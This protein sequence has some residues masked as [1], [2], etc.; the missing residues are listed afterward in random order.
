MSFNDDC[1]YCVK[2]E[3]LTDIMIEICKLEASTLYLFKEQTYKG[4]CVV[5]YNDHKSEIFELND[6]E[7]SLYMKDVARVAG[8][9]NKA[10]SPYKINYGAYADKMTHL[11]F[12]IVP[13]YEDGPSFGG[14]F[15]MSPQNKV[16]LKDDEYNQLINKIKEN[17]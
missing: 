15:E 5:A 8:A 6:D 10:F 12:H 3:R 2:D 17:L 11:H 7:R 9:L 13:K 4:R 14:T 16:L 1:F